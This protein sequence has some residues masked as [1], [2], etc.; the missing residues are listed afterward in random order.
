MDKKIEEISA[1]TIRQEQED[2][3]LNKFIPKDFSVVDEIKLDKNVYKYVGAD[4]DVK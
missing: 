1:Q 3:A 2:I 4:F